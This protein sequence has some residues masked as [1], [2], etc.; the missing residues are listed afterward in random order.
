MAAST[1][2]NKVRPSFSIHDGLGHDGPGGI[3][4]AK[5]QHVV[6]LS[7]SITSRKNNNDFRK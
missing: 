7:H 2:G 4:G 1:I 6:A 3:S 5:K